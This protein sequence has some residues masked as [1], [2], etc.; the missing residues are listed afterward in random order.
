MLISLF[1]VIL[2]IFLRGKFSH[3]KVMTFTLRCET[4]ITF[5]NFDSILCMLFYNIL[6]QSS[7][8]NPQLFKQLSTFHF[9]ALEENIKTK[10]NSSKHCYCVVL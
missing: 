4:N 3:K 6:A 7:L 5:A 10:I 8:K 2:I 1:D 9:N